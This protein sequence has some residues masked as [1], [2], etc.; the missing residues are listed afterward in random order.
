MNTKARL[1][2]LKVKS[3]KKIK[4]FKVP[5]L[6]KMNNLMRQKIK[7]LIWNLNLKSQTKNGRQ[8]FKLCKAK[9]K[10]TYNSYKMKMMR[11]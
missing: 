4:I 1:L 9:H 2:N 8:N 11:K 7:F 6:R 3:N 5:Q 10:E